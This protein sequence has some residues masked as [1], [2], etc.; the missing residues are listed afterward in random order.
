MTLPLG[1]AEGLGLLWLVNSEVGYEIS[2]AGSPWLDLCW[3]MVGVMKM[4]KL[5]IWF[6]QSSLTHPPSCCPFPSSKLAKQLI[7]PQK[8]AL[9]LWLY[10]PCD[11]SAG[12]R[13]WCWVQCPAVE[14]QLS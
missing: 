13:Q 2:Q 8:P 6:T 4:R 7:A 10:G 5:I 3:S 9:H 11:Q 14:A 12:D 1:L